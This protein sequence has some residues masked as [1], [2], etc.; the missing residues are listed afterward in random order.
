MRTG[1]SS[2]AGAGAGEF[3][4]YTARVRKESARVAALEED[5]EK[6]R[7]REEWERAQEERRRADEEKTAKNRAKRQKQKEGKKKKQKR[8]EGTSSGGA[9]AETTTTGPVPAPKGVE[10]MR[11][12]L[13]DA[14]TKSQIIPNLSAEWW[15]LSAG[16]AC[17]SAWML[18]AAAACIVS[19]EGYLSLRFR[20]VAGDV[21]ESMAARAGDYALMTPQQP[22]HWESVSAV[23]ALVLRVA[24]GAAVERPAFAHGSAPSHEG[25]YFAGPQSLAP[26]GTVRK[27]FLANIGWT[28]VSMGESAGG[29]GRSTSAM[30]CILIRGKV[31]VRTSDTGAQSYVMQ[32]RG[33]WLV[34]PPHSEVSWSGLEEGSL[35]VTVS[36]VPKAAK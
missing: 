26:E 16:T 10:L 2:I 8:N 7:V 36:G 4:M 25:K 18:Q 29:A 28:V 1:Q 11:G 30:V 35:M 15:S 5:A 19:V 23:E 24:G 12:N 14:G 22:Y 13:T 27:S 33:D 21:R 34:I 20:D 9:G 17:P 31:A 6:K 3:H 32:R